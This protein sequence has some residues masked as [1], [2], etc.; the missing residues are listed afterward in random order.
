[1]SVLSAEEL[2]EAVDVVCMTVFDM[3]VSASGQTGLLEDECMEARIDI[4]GAWQGRIQVR[5]SQQFLC[6]AASRVF[7]KEVHEIDQH[8]CI[9]TLT[10]MTN[11]LGGTVKCM[12]PEPCILG[13]PM[14]VN[15]DQD[16]TTDDEWHCFD[17]DH[18]PMAVAIVEAIVKGTQAA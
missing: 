16:T 7:L 11:M 5:A 18:Q 13:L 8:D 15:C 14:I 3:P 4:L 2:A 17:C 1:M 10:E 12:L 9:D 6:L